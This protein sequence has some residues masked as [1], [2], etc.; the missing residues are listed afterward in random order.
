MLKQRP[1]KYVKKDGA[2]KIIYTIE[3]TEKG[4][5]KKFSEDSE[6]WADAIGC[7]FELSEDNRC[8]S[9][10]AFVINPSQR[11]RVYTEEELNYIF[12]ECLVPLRKF[13]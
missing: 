6:I 4:W 13:L 5:S 2:F 12:S 3:I 11:A 9:W 8:A 7:P 1:S 10:E